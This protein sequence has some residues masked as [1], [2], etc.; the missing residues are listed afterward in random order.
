VAQQI[1]ERDD[2]D[3][4]ETQQR[5]QNPAAKRRHAFNSG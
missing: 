4:E 3:R 5:P 1:G 2:R